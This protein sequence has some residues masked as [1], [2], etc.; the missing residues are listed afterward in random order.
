MRTSA[1]AWWDGIDPGRVRVVATDMDGTLLS[2][3]G[4]VSSRTAAAVAA[5]RRAGVHVVPV[6]GRPPQALWVLAATAGLGP[7]GVCSNGAA[8]V[9]LDREEVIEV[10]H[11]PGELAAELVQRARCVE[12]E[13]RFAVDNLD[14]FTHE[15][16]FFE[17]PVEWEEDVFGTD[18]LTPVLE[19]G[20][21][22]LIARRP[23]TSALDLI[24]RLAPFLGTAVHLTTSGL[25]W[26]DIGV[27]GVTKAT[28]LARVCARLG[29]GAEA[30]VAVGD[31]HNDLTMLE[32][33]SRGLAVAN[34]AP[35][36]LA[37]AD[38]VLP[39]NAADGVAV[40]LE[41]L[42]AS[43]RAALPGTAEVG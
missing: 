13:V 15:V 14:R 2:P 8:V 42:V 12:P 33:A 24:D 5:A 1:P 4:T 17:G 3:G 6:T 20:C 10:D 9:D 7:V 16:A 26:V 27:V 31:N 21:I 25:D 43:R 40:L 29:V 18:D 30:V 34:A 19:E 39:G 41:R 28:A 23:G 37:A 22:K 36:V 11:L 32:W 38:A 35:D